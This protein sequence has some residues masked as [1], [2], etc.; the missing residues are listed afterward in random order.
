MLEAPGFIKRINR[1]W[2]KW[3]AGQ[4][5]PLATFQARMTLRKRIPPG[6]LLDSSVL[7][8]G[9]TH[10]TGWI[11][12]GVK[13]WGGKFDFDSGYMASI[14]VHSPDNDGRVYREVRY[15]ASIAYL[16]QT[17]HIKLLTSAELFAE[18]FRQPVGR[19]QGYGWADYSVF[20]G[21]QFDSVDGFH[22]DLKHPAEKQRQRINSC[23][24]PLLLELR[25]AL[26]EK[27]SQDAWHIYTAEK[28]S[29]FAFL[30]MDFPLAEKITRNKHKP[31]FNSL[32]THVMLPSEFA[33]HFRIL[34]FNTNL[35]GVLQEDT[36]FPRRDDLYMPSQQRRRHRKKT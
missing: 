8:H 31:P 20:K 34:P 30:H 10:E 36:F 29:L 23:T 3:L 22:L 27:S 24:D 18:Q 7:G 26:G 17:S 32:N 14:P 16:Y 25:K 2:K 28:H 21:M 5:L 35:M 9:V 19:F 33:A 6:V 4:M 1:K 13:K 11:S 15:L 12:T